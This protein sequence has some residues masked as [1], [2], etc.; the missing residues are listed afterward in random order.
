MRTGWC[1]T[2]R[3]IVC[4]QL[5]PSPRFAALCPSSCLPRRL[6]LTRTTFDAVLQY[7]GALPQCG[8]ASAYCCPFLHASSAAYTASCSSPLPTHTS[9]HILYD[10]VHD[11]NGRLVAMRRRLGVEY[12]MPLPPA[13]QGVPLPFP[14]LLFHNSLPPSSNSRSHSPPA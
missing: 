13:A 7:W 12:N 5:A 6:Y 4:A 1:Y 11:S 2:T 10:D 8:I 3:K 14:P 9:K